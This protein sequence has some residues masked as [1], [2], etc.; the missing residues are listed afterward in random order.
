MEPLEPPFFVRHAARRAL[1]VV[2]S[3]LAALLSPA[4][5]SVPGP[6]ETTKLKV[7]EDGTYI[8]GGVLVSSEELR[9]T[10]EAKRSA[11]GQLLVHVV[12]S[13]KASYDAVAK[14]MEAAQAAGA[15]VGI[16]GNE[17]F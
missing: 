12:A 15:K 6:V 10:L 5:G 3:L 11:R 13:P 4:C 1:L 7:C 2:F 9:S 17:R 16:V 14:A 8:L